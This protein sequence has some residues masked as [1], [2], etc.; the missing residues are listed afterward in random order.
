M[1]GLNSI[2][3][4]IISIIQKRC[5]EIQADGI[6]VFLDVSVRGLVVVGWGQGGGG[7]SPSSAL[8]ML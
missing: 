4:K 7:V 3:F 1:I 8:F 6:M 5:T 2:L